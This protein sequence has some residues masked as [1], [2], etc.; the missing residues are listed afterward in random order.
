METFE[1]CI[2]EDSYHPS[3][4]GPEQLTV[5]DPAFDRR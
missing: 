1:V 3:D 2:F 4:H 5:A